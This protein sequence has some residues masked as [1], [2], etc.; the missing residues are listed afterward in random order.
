D[1][2][3]ITINPVDNILP[4]V[5]VGLDQTVLAGST[6]EISGSDSSDEDGKIVSYQWKRIDQANVEIDEF[7]DDIKTPSHRFST[8]TS[9]NTGEL[10][11]SLTVT[12]NEGGQAT[13]TL[14]IIVLGEREE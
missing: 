5:N 8:S 13:D 4:I 14:T 11:F 9:A 7:V 3:N 2:A 1:V 12:D 6:V 10:I